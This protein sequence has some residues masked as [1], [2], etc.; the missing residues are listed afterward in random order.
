VCRK[1]KKFL[2][3]RKHKCSYKHKYPYTFRELPKQETMAREEGWRR[4]GRERVNTV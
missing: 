2:N 3:I 4:G 1:K